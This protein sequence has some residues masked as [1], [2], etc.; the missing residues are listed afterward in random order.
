MKNSTILSISTL[1]LGLALSTNAYAQVS[2]S[3]VQVDRAPEHNSDKPAQNSVYAEGLGAGLAY[4]I[5]YERIFVDEIAL[6]GGFSY[7]SSSASATTSSGTTTATASYLTFPITVSYFGLRGRKSS[8]EVGG[9]MTLTYASGSA[10]ALGVSASASGIAPVGTLLL[11][12]RL[13]PV[14]GAGF[15]F[16]VGG[17]ALAAKGFSL[18][19]PDPEAFGVL[20]WLYLSM[21]A[22]FG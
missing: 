18:S 11:G 1:G 17:M 22:S 9:G 13:H 6:R 16:R 2:D 7:L 19:N 8:L 3:G 20:P 15:Q 5:N 4:S 10:S 12:Y 14:G 21:G